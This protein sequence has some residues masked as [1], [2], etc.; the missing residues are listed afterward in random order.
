MMNNDSAASSI[1][2]IPY[3]LQISTMFSISA[4]KPYVCTGTQAPILC[5]AL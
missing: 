3:P 5:P 2:G 4:G 1:T